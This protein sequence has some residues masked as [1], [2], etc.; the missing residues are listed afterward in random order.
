MTILTA[1]RPLPSPLSMTLP[2]LVFRRGCPVM[3]CILRHSLLLFVPPLR[4]T[5]FFLLLPRS[6]A[7]TI[8][9]NKPNTSGTERNGPITAT[10]VDDTPGSPGYPPSPVPAKSACDMDAELSFE[11]SVEDT[12]LPLITVSHAS[13]ARADAGCLT[14]TKLWDYITSAPA[15]VDLP[16]VGFVPGGSPSNYS[17]FTHR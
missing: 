16:E 13:G 6:V 4:C 3:S 7:A 12:K 9:K 14:M 1:L 15:D 5:F 10:P 8:C 17:W 2:A 11:Y